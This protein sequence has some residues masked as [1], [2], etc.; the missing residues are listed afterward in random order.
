MINFSEQLKNSVSTHTCDISFLMI[1]NEYH[2][3]AYINIIC[4]IVDAPNRS[5]F[6]LYKKKDVLN[7]E[8]IIHISIFVYLVIAQN[9]QFLSVEA[10]KCSR[11]K[12]FSDIT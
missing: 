6:K 8:R 2:N 10:M 11:P 12:F 4:L 1:W 5:I 3:M 9:H 7:L